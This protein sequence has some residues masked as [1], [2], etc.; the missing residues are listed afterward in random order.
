MPHRHHIHAKSYD[1]TKEKICEYSQS[2]HALPHWKFVLRYCAKCPSINLPDHEIDDKH[3][4]PSPLIRFHVYHMIACCKKHGMLPLTDKK[5]CL[6]FQQDIASVK[7]TKIYTRK[8]LMM[9]ERTISNFRTSFYIP[10]I[11]KLV[12]QIPHVHILGTNNCGDSRW[13]AFKHSE[14]LQDVLCRREYDEGLVAIFAH[15][16]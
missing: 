10:E 2:D 12:F 16:I 6:E 11:Q 4:N 1:M 14:S 15:Q 8:E 9:M 13:T 3:P 5:I 7:S